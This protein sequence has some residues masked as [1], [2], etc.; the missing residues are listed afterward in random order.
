[1]DFNAAIDIIIKDLREAQQIID[2]LRKYPGVPSFQIELAKTKCESAAG[3]IEFLKGYKAE[4][5]NSNITASEKAEIPWADTPSGRSQTDPGQ[6]PRRVTPEA[7]PPV[8][9]NKVNEVQRTN[10]TPAGIPSGLSGVI[11]SEAPAA[12]KGVESVIIADKFSHLSTRFNEQLG[13]GRTTEDMS[14]LMKSKPLANLSE[15]IGINDKFLFIR[16]IFKGN[17][18]IYSQ[19][20][21]RLDHTGSLPEARE[22]IMG[23]KGDDEENEAVKQL[24]DIVKR[25]FPAHE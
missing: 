19:A 6:G 17:K 15:A 14:E 8:A 2:D 22:L 5:E 24:L 9:E 4:P 11:H 12:K 25:K 23:Y 20:I 7:P 21:T 18:E 16:E 10:G 1:M 13:S 3:F